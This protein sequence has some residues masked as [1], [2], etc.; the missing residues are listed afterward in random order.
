MPNIRTSIEAKLAQAQLAINNTIADPDLSAALAV[1]GY[2]AER[3]RQGAALRDTARGLY[4]RQKGEYGNLLSAGDALEVARR[5]AKDTYMRHVKVARV[6]LKADRGALQALNL[7]AQRR[8][9]LSG[10][11]AQAQQFY[12]NALVERTIL[13]RL[14][15]F[16]I[17][18]VL[19]AKGQSQIDAVAASDAARQQRQGAAQ[20][21]TKA[22]DAAIATMDAWMSDFVKIA[23][24]ALQDRPQL[25]EKIGV[26]APSRRALR[27]SAPTTMSATTIPLGATLSAESVAVVDEPAL[28]PTAERRNGRAVLNGK[29]E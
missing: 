26:A 7:A 11:L 17:T 21:S 6:A 13:D 5:Q 15:P 12:A 1:Y 20:H 4:Q 24:V 10:W 29:Q 3:M 14:A 19:L 28:G 25:L 16:G 9:F 2:T 18:P 27:P 22:R 8:R 23:R